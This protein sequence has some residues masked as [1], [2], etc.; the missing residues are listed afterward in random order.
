M[1]RDWNRAYDEDDTPWDK[2]YASPPLGEFL[3]KH[4][5]AGSVLIPGCGS[6]H[7][8]RLVAKSDTRVV[9]MDIAPSALKK[10]KTFPQPSNVTYAQGD[11]LNP[12]QAH[13]AKYD[14]VVEHTCLCAIEPHE[15]AAYVKALRSVLK[16][17]GCYIAVFFREVADP[18]GGGP[19]HP[20]SE[21]ETNALFSGAFELIDSFVPTKIYPSRPLGGEQV[22][23]WR[24]RDA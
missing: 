16:P 10:A 12:E 17:N 11:F 13:V 22:C 7:D 20:I 5:I 3:E 23:L 19:P 4:S 8:V 9:G 14:W 21:E 18:A 15:R 2:G 24:S 1:P 6:G